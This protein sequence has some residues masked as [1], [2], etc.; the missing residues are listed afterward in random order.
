[1]GLSY[2]RVYMDSTPLRH[3]AAY[4]LL[5]RFGV[6]APVGCPIAGIR[7]VDNTGTL[8]AAPDVTFDA[9]EIERPRA[10]QRGR[11]DAEDDDAAGRLAGHES[12][13]PES[14]SV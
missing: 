3:R 8:L 10:Q 7:I 4:R 12:T 13:P 6:Q 11:G 2:A 9:R 14:G 1:M 5:S